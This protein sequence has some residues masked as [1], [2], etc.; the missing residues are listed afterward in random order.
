MISDEQDIAMNDDY[1]TINFNEFIHNDEDNLKNDWKIIPICTLWPDT[2]STVFIGIHD[3][4]LIA[5]SIDTCQIYTSTASLNDLK[6]LISSNTDNQTIFN[7]LFKKRK[8]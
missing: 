8:S 4:T 6:E 7:T 5:Y 1:K 2:D 3:N